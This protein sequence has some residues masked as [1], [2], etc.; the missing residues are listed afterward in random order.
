M[1]IHLDFNQFFN[2]HDRQMI[3][4]VLNGTGAAY[5]ITNCCSKETEYLLKFQGKFY[6]YTN[7]ERYQD[8]L[9]LLP[10]QNGN[11]LLRD[12]IQ[13]H[14]SNGTMEIDIGICLKEGMLTEFMDRRIFY[15][16]EDDYYMWHDCDKE[17]KCKKIETKK[18]IEYI[19]RSK[20]GDI[21]AYQIRPIDN[22]E[23]AQVEALF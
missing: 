3:Q 8:D 15:K 23:L 16:G 10:Y 2:D 6:I 14:L 13:M 7:S 21:L 4:K 20:Q 1:D 12:I 11:E 18:V 22:E 19:I 17:D 9:Y 5:S